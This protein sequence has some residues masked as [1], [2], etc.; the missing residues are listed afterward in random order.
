[1]LVVVSLIY[2]FDINSGTLHYT[3]LATSIS[4]HFTCFSKEK[5]FTRNWN[6]KQPVHKKRFCLITLNELS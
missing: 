6:V 5:C 3:L 2:L 1:M 4:H